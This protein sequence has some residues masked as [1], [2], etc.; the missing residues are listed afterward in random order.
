MPAHEGFNRVAQLVFAF[1]AGPVES[2]PLEQAEYDFNL[3]QPACRGRREMK[4]DATFVL[5]QPS[6]FFLWG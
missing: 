5:C 4:T 2:L 1:K 3:I 6:S